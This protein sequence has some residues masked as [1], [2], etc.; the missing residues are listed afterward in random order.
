M[1]TNT[2]ITIDL[3][4]AAKQLLVVKLTIHRVYGVVRRSDLSS[5]YEA[6]EKTGEES[7]ETSLRYIPK[8]WQTTLR[9]TYNPIKRC[10]QKNTLP[11][12]DGGWRVVSAGRYESLMKDAR[13]LELIHQQTVADMVAQYDEIKRVAKKRLGKLWNESEFPTREGLESQLAVEFAVRPISKTNDVR[14]TG[15]TGK[16]LQSVQTSMGWTAT[17]ARI[18]TR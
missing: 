11:Y 5:K 16:T 18:R 10:W 1:A 9:K 4:A 12:E 8:S 7:I 3:T 2:P 6:L 17:P 13:R 15:L 14:L